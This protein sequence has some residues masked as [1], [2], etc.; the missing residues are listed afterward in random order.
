MFEL[1]DID[2]ELVAQLGLRLGKG[3]HLAIKL[4]RSSRFGFRGLFLLLIS[5]HVPLYLDL[6]RAHGRV[7]MEFSQFVLV[8]EG[9]EARLEP[10]RKVSPWSLPVF[11]D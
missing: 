5:S 11:A 8:D 3:E 10:V 6:F 9:F 1:L 2:I 7:K 4:V